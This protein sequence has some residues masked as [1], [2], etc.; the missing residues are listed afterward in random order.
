M[1]FHVGE[2]CGQ[3]FLVLILKRAMLE[4]EKPK[5]IILASQRTITV[6]SKRTLPWTFSKQ[7]PINIV[8]KLNQRK[9]SNRAVHISKSVG[10]HAFRQE[11]VFRL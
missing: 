11:F 2:F 9:I 4:E 10:K 8:S 3:N 6:E 5:C 1:K 7:R